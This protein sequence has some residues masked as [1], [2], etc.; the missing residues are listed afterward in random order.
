MSLFARH[1]HNWHVKISIITADEK[2]ARKIE[3]GVPS[4]EERIAAIKRLADLGVHVT[5]RLRPF[6][7]GVSTDFKKLIGMAHEAGA[8][9]VTTE[10]FCMEA[11]ANEAL[12]KR[13]A[14]M[15][16][17]CGFDI[18]KYYMENSKQ[19][20]YKRTEPGNKSPDYP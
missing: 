11:R 13:Y 16:K 18:H 1:T 10:F 6:I 12:K 17:A 19:H 15:S 9:S 8:D 4:P 7:L 2:K 5:L 14:E 20:G 3:K